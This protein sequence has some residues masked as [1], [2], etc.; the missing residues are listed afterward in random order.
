MSEFVK[1]TKDGEIIE[2]HPDALADHMRLGWVVV[3]QR[4]EADER[5][6]QRIDADKRMSVEAKPV[7]KKA[8][9]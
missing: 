1:V 6:E 3:E 2:V 4:I 9:K 5:I 7:K 8:D